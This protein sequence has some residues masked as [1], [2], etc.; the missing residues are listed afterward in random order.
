[1]N[2]SE[3]FKRLEIEYK[4]LS[5]SPLTNIGCTVGLFQEDDI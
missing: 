4:N 2:S 3:G 1:M 5:R